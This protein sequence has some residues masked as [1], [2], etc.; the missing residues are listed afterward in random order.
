M[1]ALV[2][3]LYNHGVR[4]S[5][6]EINADPGLAGMLSLYRSG[7]RFEL[8]L[9]AFGNDSVRTP[10][11]PVLLDA[12]AISMHHGKI[13]WRGLQHADNNATYLQEWSSCLIGPA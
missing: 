3:Q 4:R 12:T 8:S 1:Q 13:L 6:R 9:H 2:K 10:L 5:D 7:G 11:I